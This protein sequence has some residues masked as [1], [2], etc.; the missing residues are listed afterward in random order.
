MEDLVRCG[1]DAEKNKGDPVLGVKKK[2]WW[3]FIPLAHYMVP[4]IHCKNWGRKSTVRSV[5]SNN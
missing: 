3:L 1:K 5:T 2:P 4:L